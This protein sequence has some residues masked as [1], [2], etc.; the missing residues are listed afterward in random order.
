MFLDY[1]VKLAYGRCA[2][3]NDPAP[4]LETTCRGEELPDYSDLIERLRELTRWGSRPDRLAAA[5][6]LESL[7][8]RV[9]ELEHELSRYEHGLQAA[10]Q[11]DLDIGSTFEQAP[12]R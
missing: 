4:D 12:G 1:P 8:R 5:D 7:I 2:A 9:A 10:G 3:G 6:A 11:P